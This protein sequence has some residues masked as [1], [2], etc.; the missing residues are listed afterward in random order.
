MEISLQNLYF[1]AEHYIQDV[2][3]TPEKFLNYQVAI[4]HEDRTEMIAL[5]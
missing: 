3:T 4:E 5:R 1:T 2:L